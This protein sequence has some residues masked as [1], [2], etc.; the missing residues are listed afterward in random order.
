MPC[1][2]CDNHQI[3]KLANVIFAV[4]KIT[5]L[6]IIDEQ[7]GIFPAGFTGQGG[8]SKDLTVWLDGAR[9]ANT[10]IPP[11][12]LWNVP[13]SCAAYPPQKYIC[14]YKKLGVEIAKLYMTTIY[15]RTTILFSN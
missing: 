1:S 3:V 4:A 14:K 6:Y 9:L 2:I 13:H 10:C 15:N 5:K 11:S 8:L 7:F 12:F